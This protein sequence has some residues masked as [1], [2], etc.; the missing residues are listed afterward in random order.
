MKPVFSQYR[1]LD[2]IGNNSYEAL[3]TDIPGASGAD[4]ALAFKVQGFSLPGVEQGRL[5]VVVQ[6]FKFYN[7]SG[8]SI[9]SG[10]FNITYFEDADFSVNKTMR[11]WKEVTSGTESG[12]AG[13]NKSAYARDII[14]H[15]LNPQGVV[16]GELTVFG[17]F[18]VT[19]PELTAE[20]TQTPNPLTP[21]ISFSYDYHQLTGVSIR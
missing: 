5:E 3:I 20:S 7:S 10:Q 12:T 4:K 17:C 9:F 15:L 1:N 2:V 16:S 14:L 19:I 21:T 6:G 8:S 13:G 11:A 18:P